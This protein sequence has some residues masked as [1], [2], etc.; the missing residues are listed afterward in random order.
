MRGRKRNN[1][2]D[3]ISIYILI[4]IWLMSRSAIGWRTWT[5]SIEDAADV[6]YCCRFFHFVS[7]T[8][9][10]RLVA[11]A[12]LQSLLLHIFILNQLCGKR[13]KHLQLSNCQYTAG[14]DETR[15]PAFVP[16][17]G[18]DWRMIALYSDV[19]YMYHTN[20]GL[21][22][23][24]TFAPVN[25]SHLIQ[26]METT[27]NQPE[28][29]ADVRGNRCHSRSINNAH[30]IFGTTVIYRSVSY[31]YS[32]HLKKPMHFSD[33]KKIGRR[34]IFTEQRCRWKL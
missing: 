23:S 19:L 21:M 11:S 20:Y 7:P 2:Q 1:S 24:S 15:P 10:H 4:W 22:I 29:S 17:P 5:R 34:F 14:T 30:F 25:S 32:G 27:S 6:F 31:F 8:S 9:S 26:K 33:D 13:K 16:N 12:E 3:G 18:D 28:A